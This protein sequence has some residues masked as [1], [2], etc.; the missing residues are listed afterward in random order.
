MLAELRADPNVQGVMLGG[1]L[2]RGTARPDSDLDVFVVTAENDDDAPWRRRRRLLPVDLLAYTAND[3]RG[4]FCPHRVGDESWGYAFM[5]GII[6]EDPAGAL[7]QL[8]AE[9]AEIHA[10][11]RVPAH[12][13]AHYDWLWKHV[14]PKMLAVLQR[15][16]PVEIGWAAAAMTNEVVRTVWAANDLPNPSLDLGTFQRHLDG[17]TVP[18]DAP[19]RL[20]D[21]LQA[22]PKQALQLQLDLITLVEPHLVKPSVELR[23]IED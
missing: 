23:P 17:L 22:P 6:L 13:K 15:G 8:L 11:Y 19:D 2:A 16:D 10:C 18:P 12:I 1:S 5:D 4:R 20:R 7:A 14:R 21:M 9:A 3:W